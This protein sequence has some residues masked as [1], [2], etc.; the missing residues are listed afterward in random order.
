MRLMIITDLPSS[1]TSS[2]V[3]N[4]LC[5]DFTAPRHDSEY[6]SEYYTVQPL[7]FREIK[8]RSC[9]ALLSWGLSAGVKPGR[10]S[11]SVERRS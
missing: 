4:G 6:V 9:A 7:V 1:R 5:G 3:P 11:G 8:V 10:C 2:A